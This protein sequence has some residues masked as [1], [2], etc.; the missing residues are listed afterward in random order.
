MVLVVSGLVAGVT[1]RTV[2]FSSFFSTRCGDC[3]NDD[4]ISCAGCHFHR[5]NLSASTDQSA[6]YPNDP[7]VI[8]LDSVGE[9]S[10][11]VRGILY[12]H[13]GAFVMEVGGPTGTGDDGAGS[14]IT[15]PIEFTFNAPP[16]IG[17]YT[18]EAAWYGS[19]NSGTEHIEDRE[20]V[21][22]RVES[23]ADVDDDWGPAIASGQLRLAAYPNPTHDTSTLRFGIGPDAGGARLHIVDA[24]GRVVRDMGFLASSNQV[25]ELRWDGRDASGDPVSAGAYFAVLSNQKM[26]VTERILVLK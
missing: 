15:F 23:H 11:W 24:N 10:G 1:D 4:T 16:E 25:Q 20:P 3:H 5:G 17:D 13:T 19:N 12:D 14:P 7:V 26:D 6:Y 18:Y 8:T 9:G 21:L 22:V 2:A